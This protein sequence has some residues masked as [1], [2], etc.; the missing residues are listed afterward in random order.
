MTSGPAMGINKMTGITPRHPV[1]DVGLFANKAK[2]IVI[3][4]SEP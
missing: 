4:D 1:I 3:H 2:I